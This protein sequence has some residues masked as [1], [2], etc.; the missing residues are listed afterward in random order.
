MYKIRINSFLYYFA[1][2]IW[3]FIN[4]LYTTRLS[5]NFSSQLN[6]VVSGIT[7]LTFLLLVTKIVVE[8]K[9][10]IYFI[11]G[12]GIIFPV[13]FIIG[14]QSG[15]LMTFI[16]LLLLICCIRDVNLKLVVKIHV[17]ISSFILIFTQILLMLG[18]TYDV[19]VANSTGQVFHYM[20]YRYLSYPPNI[21]FHM[22]CGLIYIR[23]SKIKYFELIVLLLINYFYYLKTD[24][25]SAFFFTILVIL[26]SVFI[27]INKI[28]FSY[29]N[30]IILFLERYLIPIETLLVYLLSKWYSSGNYFFIVLDK[31]LSNRVR[32]G[33]DA[34]Q[35]YGVS[36][37]GN[38]IIWNTQDVDG[39]YRGRYLFVDSSFLNILIN[40]GLIAMFL[41]IIGY[42]ILS[43][44]NYYRTIYFSVAFIAIILHSMWD[45][46]FINIWY[47]PF[48]PFLGIYFVQNEVDKSSVLSE[49]G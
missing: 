1:F 43:W 35:L 36:I 14:L 3:I 24:V 39:I 17:I 8:N 30:R 4:L 32:L 40:Y 13:I 7:Y 10:R 26:S 11:I 49:R 45:P 21:L 2:S 18:Y 38:R 15:K 28:N 47:N 34:L 9:V 6:W 31:F 23:G 12:I 25:I 16:N 48:L 42:Y 19:T 44:C 33:S 27:K 41:I 22:V 20:G 29:S 5:V 46:Q 37:F